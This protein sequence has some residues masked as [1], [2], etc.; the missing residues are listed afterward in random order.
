MKP[1]DE[2]VETPANILARV[3]ASAFIFT[4][5]NTTQTDE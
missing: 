4:V 2:R 1:D 5:I 3:Q